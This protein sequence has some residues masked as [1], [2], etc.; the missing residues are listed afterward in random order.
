MGCNLWAYVEQHDKKTG[1]WKYLSLYKKNKDD[2]Y[3]D[4]F[5]YA[6]RDY[7]LFGM[8]A[9]VR[10][11][12]SPFVD[13]RG[14]PDDMS[15]ELNEKYGDG[16]NWHSSTWYDYCE[17]KAYSRMLNKSEKTIKRLENEV[18]ELGKRVR[19]LSP[20]EDDDTSV[21]WWDFDRDDDDERSDAERLSYFVACIDD[22]LMIYHVYKIMPGDIRIVMWFNS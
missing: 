8:L 4:V 14:V 18:L 15:E 21:D 12:N 5:M 11:F 17:L 20:K 1:A 7:E 13:K 22:L 10:S 9:G 19:D 2:T 16:R 6:S 3:D